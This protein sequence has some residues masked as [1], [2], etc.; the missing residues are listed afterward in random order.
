MENMKGKLKVDYKDG[1]NSGIIKIVQE[2][3]DG[4]NT[5]FPVFTMGIRARGIGASPA[6]EMAQTNYMSNSLEYGFDIDTWHPDTR[7]DWF[8]KEAK[9]V[10]DELIYEPEEKDGGSEKRTELEK[11]QK[12]LNKREKFQKEETMYTFAEF[13]A[14]E[15]VELDEK[16]KPLTLAQRNKKKMSFRRSKMKRKISMERNRKKISDQRKTT[17]TN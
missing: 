17:N 7:N 15:E 4:S 9:R 16:R 14:E 3:E 11:Y 12:Y 13:L 5:E 2:M 10:A 1:A 8:K 6:F